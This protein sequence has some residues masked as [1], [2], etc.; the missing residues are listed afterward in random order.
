M[1]AGVK[2][3]FGTDVGAFPHGTNNREFTYMVDYGMS[4]IEAIRSATT[5]A[6]E[7]LRMEN[8]IGTIAAGHFA[9]LIAV[10][11]DPLQNIEAIK[12]VRFV[13]KG[14]EVFVTPG[15][16]ARPGISQ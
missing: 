11:G 7:L 13:M 16:A 12:R 3:V 9:D 15:A 8:D 2:I 14:G 6:A 1:K 5:R 4:P 10:D